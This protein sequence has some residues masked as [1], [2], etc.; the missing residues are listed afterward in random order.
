MA[1][2]TRIITAS[3]SS[4]SPPRTSTRPAT[5]TRTCSAWRSRSAGSMPA[6]EFEAGNLTI[7]VMQ[8]DAFGVEHSTNSSPIE[9]H[10]DDFEGAKAEL[11]SRGV[12]FGASRST[13]AS[14]SRPSSGTPTA[15]PWRSTTGTRNDGVQL[16]HLKSWVGVGNRGDSP[17]VAGHGGA[18]PDHGGVA[19]GREVPSP[20]R[21]QTIP[22]SPTRSR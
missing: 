12:K 7:A 4:P 20:P 18:R 5:S 6:Q 16:E 8:S 17:D 15:T 3:T 14:A 1:T 21:A 11:D 9:F 2:D 13:L 19:G 10:V 22:T